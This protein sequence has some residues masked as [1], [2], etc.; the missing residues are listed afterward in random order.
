MRKQKKLTG[1]LIIVIFVGF[2]GF[3]N[4]ATTDSIIIAQQNEKIANLQAQIDELKGENITT[5]ATVDEED[6]CERDLRMFKVTY[7]MFLC[8][9][10]VL[11]IGGFIC[12]KK[13]ISLHWMYLLNSKLVWVG[14]LFFNIFQPLSEF[15]GVCFSSI[16]FVG[17]LLIPMTFLLSDRG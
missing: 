7:F 4:N 8:G 17:I 3:A 13:G 15:W 5:T 11:L 14:F 2:I 10:F 1:L 6:D 12:Y 16:A 9:G